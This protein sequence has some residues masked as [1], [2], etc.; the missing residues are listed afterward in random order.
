MIKLFKRFYICKIL[1]IFT[2]FFMFI[3]VKNSR[4]LDLDD[5]EKDLITSIIFFFDITKM[6][7]Y[8][9]IFY[10]ILFLID[11]N[12]V[13]YVKYN[14]NF[15]TIENNNLELV[16]INEIDDFLCAICLDN[17]DNKNKL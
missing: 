12:F 1:L 9:L 3:N 2:D 13:L 4:E 7:Y 16:N 8:F 15:I 6:I 11:L 5:P 10:T 17:E 14:T